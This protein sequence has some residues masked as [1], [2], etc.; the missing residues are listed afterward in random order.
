MCWCTCC[1]VM[2]WSWCSR[3]AAMRLV[4]IGA[5]CVDLPNPRSAGVSP[6]HMPQISVWPACRHCCWMG[7]V[8]QILRARL[9]DVLWF[10]VSGNQSSLGWYRHAAMSH[11]SG[12]IVVGS[13]S[14]LWAVFGAPPADATDVGGVVVYTGG[15]FFAALVAVLLWCRRVVG[16]ANRSPCVWAGCSAGFRQCGDA[17]RRSRP[18]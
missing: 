15:Y 9:N 8:A 7:Q 5:V 1:T 6:P 16:H 3:S 12:V 17:Q 13:F 18:C 11:S 14:A 4:D 10:P 2:G